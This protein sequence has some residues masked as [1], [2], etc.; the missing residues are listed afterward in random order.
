M[1]LVSHINKDGFDF[2]ALLHWSGVDMYDVK[3]GQYKSH[4]INCE[5]M[6]ALKR[7]GRMAAEGIIKDDDP[8]WR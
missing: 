2:V 1:S 5:D 3:T 8:V 6:D 4:R 7:V